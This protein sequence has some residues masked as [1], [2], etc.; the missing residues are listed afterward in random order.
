MALNTWVTGVYTP[1]KC[2]HYVTCKAGRGG[3][4]EST[5]LIFHNG[6]SFPRKSP[7]LLRDYLAG[8]WKGAKELGVPKIPS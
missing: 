7:A 6:K 1:Y 2:T 5:S 4:L 3:H 8:A